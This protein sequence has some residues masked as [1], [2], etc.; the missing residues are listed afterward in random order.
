MKKIIVGITGGSCTLY[1]VALL[2]ALKCLNIE[3]HTI[4]SKMGYYNLNHECEV[5]ESEIRALS[6]FYYE[7]HDLAARVASGSFRTDSMVIVPCSMNTL[8]AIANGTSQ[9]LIHR[10]ADV[11]IKERRKLVIVP[12]EMPLSPVH[13]ENM[14]KLS[15]MGVV[16]MPASPGFYHKPESIEDLVLIMVGRLLDQFDLET[17]LFKRWHSEEGS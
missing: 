4:V 14:L 8:G 1:A 16:V 13:L 17:N 2:K 3:T 7:N 15:Q 10:A 11:V 12:R 9:N 5:S 6:S